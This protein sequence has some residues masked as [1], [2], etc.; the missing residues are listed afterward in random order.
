MN[1]EQ[2]SQAFKAIGAVIGV[3]PTHAPQPKTVTAYWTLPA[4][5]SALASAGWGDLHGRKWQGVRSTLH[6][7]SAKLNHKT[8]RG[9][10]TAYQLADAAGLSERWT[11]VCLTELETLGL[12]TWERGGILRG[13][14]L[15]SYF[16]VNKKLLAALVRSARKSNQ[17]HRDKRAR[18][19]AKRLLSLS[20]NTVL[21]GKPGELP[22][23]SASHSPLSG[24]VIPPTSPDGKKSQNNSST[25]GATMLTMP[26]P[27]PSQWVD[28]CPHEGSPEPSIIH[29]CPDC[30]Y[31]SMSVDE[32]AE[33]E[34]ECLKFERLRAKTVTANSNTHKDNARDY[35][36][37]YYYPGVTGV[38]LAKA[39]L[40]DRQAG[41]V[42]DF[43]EWYERS[44][45]AQTV[46][47]V[48]A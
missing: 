10:T 28:Y 34:G 7:L 5:L 42:P 13:N 16:T 45:E 35:F 21:R 8:G 1:Q 18:E 3:K 44:L 11:R 23:L 15:P 24:E 12:I 41:R 46:Q 25:I 27:R 40:A 20:K 37:N 26:V 19:F 22:E 32:L 14:R 17:A 48:V 2:M 31:A 47:E 43:E 33:Y 39:Y 38:A 29:S 6:A 36:Y 9:H 30:R 4:L